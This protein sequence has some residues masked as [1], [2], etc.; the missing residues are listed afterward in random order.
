MKTIA[1]QIK[2]LENTRAAK[3]ARMAEVMQ[4]SID[5]GRS[6]DDAEGEEVDTLDVEVKRL[7]SDLVRL[8]RM[9][10]MQ[11]EQAAPAAGTSQKAASES[12]AGS[13]SH[14]TVKSNSP[15]GSAF[16]RM[17]MSQVVGKGDSM[18]AIE[19]ARRTWPDSP[20]VET[21]VK[22]AVAAGTT[23]D[24]TWAGPLA[25]VRPLADEFIDILRPAS[26]IA[27]IPGLRT[28]PF[29]VSVPVRTAGGTYGWVGQGAAKPMTKNDFATISVGE[30]KVA[31]I[32][33]IS[34]ELA[35]RSTP[36]AEKTIRD[37][38][39]KGISAFIDGQ[40]LD[41]AVAATTGNPASITNGVTAIT[42]AG[43]SSANARTDILALLNAFAVANM[44][45]DS[46]VF[47]MS[48]GNAVALS[49]ALNALGQP[50]FPSVTRTGGQLFGIPVV[51]S[52]AAGSNVILLD[53]QSIL[54]ADEGGV[55][56]DVSDQASVQMDSAPDN[57]TSAT[58]VMVSLWQRNLIGIRA[59]RFVSWTR[60]R[61]VA[62]QYTVATYTVA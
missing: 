62:V 39:V 42:T 30:S 47:V 58:T 32:I 29:N 49:V 31:G 12:R 38:M 21:M 52:S 59:E 19:H 33:A 6:T 1:E 5:E 15:K 35:R 54:I 2:D 23:T 8:R 61:L 7:D 24:A 40:F 14:I 53:A 50:L 20:E 57:P 27:R 9:E 3:A 44:D 48:P 17:I 11:M 60:A 10:K 36:D 4:K 26:V 41:P 18:R 56:V 28:V 25:L 55:N 51:V 13:A 22:A 46:L 34:Q 16:T 37:D 43:T 45:T